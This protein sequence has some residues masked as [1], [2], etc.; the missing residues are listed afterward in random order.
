MIHLAPH[1]IIFSTRTEDFCWKS[2]PSWPFTV[3][4][5]GT[6]VIA[7]VLS[8]Y[9]VVG[10]A[11]VEGIGWVR[12]IIIVAIALVTFVL[13]DLVKVLTIRLW[14]RHHSYNAI[15]KKKP[16]LSASLQKMK[17]GKESTRA[18]RFNQEHALQWDERQEGYRG[19]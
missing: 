3:V 16:T 6:Q 15:V 5:L 10:D 17:Q 14:N 2:L 13:V 9:G 18:E 19:Y 12:G 11:R 7:L 1:F 8:V 4:V